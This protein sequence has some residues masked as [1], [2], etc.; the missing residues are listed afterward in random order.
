[1][2]DAGWQQ[3]CGVGIR[4]VAMAIDSVIWFGLFFVATTTV[5]AV[6]GELEMTGGELT[7][8]LTG[9]PALVAFVGWLGLGI[10]YHTFF[11][12]RSGRTLGK[13]LVA[14]RVVRADGGPLT[15]RTLAMR[16]LLRLVDWLPLFYGVGIVVLVASEENQRLGDRLAG[17]LV[18]R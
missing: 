8:N 13:R 18:V 4:G 12:W 17:T 1:M 6:T 14:I 9:L 15:L 3:R 10:G 7:A 11:E 2:S 16:N 5:G